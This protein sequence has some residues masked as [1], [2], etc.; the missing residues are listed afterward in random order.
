MDLGITGRAAIVTG[1][2]KGIGRACVETLLSEGAD[3]CAV[4]RDVWLLDDLVTSSA[5]HLVTASC[6][7]TTVEGCD[8]AVQ[9][10][11]DAF[12]QIDILIN[13]A[14]S[15]GMGNVLEISANDVDRA[16]LLKFHGYLRMAQ[17]V[18]PSMAERGWGRIVNI[19][20]SA[21][22]SPTA[23]NLPTSLA[24][25]AVHNLTRAL[26]D[27]LTPSGIQVNLV[28]PGLTLTDRAVTLF[29]DAARQQGRTP[30]ELIDEVGTA[31]PAGRPANPAEVARVACFLASDACSYVQASALYMDG[32]A[33]R[34][35][36]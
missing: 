13:C 30:Q 34:A 23:N 1:G 35:T 32:G 5:G 16:L 3:V 15:A 19:A 2:S 6:D 28:A 29:T 18:A 9:T 7:L 21:G 11:L 20:G 12:D 36:P 27:E 4:S 33:R 10:C 31:L 17:R 14:G 24:N 26:S 8:R 25:I 22:T